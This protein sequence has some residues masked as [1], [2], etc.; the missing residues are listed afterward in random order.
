MICYEEN[1]M[2]YGM[3]PS[4][5]DERDWRIPMAVDIAK[6]ITTLFRSNKYIQSFSDCAAFAFAQ[7]T[8][9]NEF[10]Q[11]GV[12]T[13]YSPGYTYAARKPLDWQ[14]EGMMPRELLMQAMMIGTVPYADFPHE[15]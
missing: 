11:R 4:I 15:G 8:E 9:A 3:L 10:R 12:R 5:E 2:K 6:P 14:R 1:Y 13:R 7:W